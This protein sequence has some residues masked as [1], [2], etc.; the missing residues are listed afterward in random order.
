MNWV[1]LTSILNIKFYKLKT[2]LTN[3]KKRQATRQNE[4]VA[5]GLFVSIDK[6]ILQPE[7]HCTTY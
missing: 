5:L 1:N 2:N 6:Q 4:R 3:L 7:Y